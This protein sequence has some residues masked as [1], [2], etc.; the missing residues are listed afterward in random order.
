M[1]LIMKIKL[2]KKIRKRYS[3]IFLDGIV[4]VWDKKNCTVRH[5]HKIQDFISWAVCELIGLGSYFNY[6]DKCM[7]RKHKQQWKE[8]SG[9]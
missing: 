8:L 1:N 2:L 5:H 3:Y 9:K 6:S 7:K 4:H